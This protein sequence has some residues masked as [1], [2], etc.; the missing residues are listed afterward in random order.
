VFPLLDLRSTSL[1][2][3]SDDDEDAGEQ[4]ET[5][6]ELMLKYGGTDGFTTAKHRHFYNSQISTPSCACVERDR[7]SFENIPL[8]R[9]WF[10]CAFPYLP[11][12]PD[13]IH[14]SNGRLA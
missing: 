2:D 11:S 14:M 13:C 12:F 10:T 9:L 7:P 5:I 6:D 3:P 1:L 8:S 4:D